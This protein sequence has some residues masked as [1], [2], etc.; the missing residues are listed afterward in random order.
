MRKDSRCG[1]SPVPTSAAA[2]FANHAHHPRL[3]AQAFTLSVRAGMHRFVGTCTT[4]ARCPG[5]P[6]KYRFARVARSPGAARPV[7]GETHRWRPDLQPASAD[8]GRPACAGFAGGAAAAIR[9]CATYRGAT[10]ETCRGF[11]AGPPRARTARRLAR[12]GR[13][14]RR[15]AGRRT[16][17][18]GRRGRRGACGESGQTGRGARRG[19]LHHALPR[20]GLC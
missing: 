1:G 16:D 10:H 6:G 17:P 5:G 18:Q 11:G 8:Q 12:Q 19:L 15:P 3:D 9:S 2:G 20:G 14:R 7:H 4:R 13:W